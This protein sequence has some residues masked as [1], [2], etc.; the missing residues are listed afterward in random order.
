MD[1][2]F[3]K[4]GYMANGGEVNTTKYNIVDDGVVM[5]SN[6]GFQE[7][8]DYANTLAH[9]DLMD[10]SEFGEFDEIATIKRCHEIP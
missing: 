2:G 9:Y 5:K 6:V 8:I 7:V 4:G 10:E 1:Y 3:E